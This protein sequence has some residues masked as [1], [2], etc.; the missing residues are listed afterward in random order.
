MQTLP[1]LRSDLQATPVYDADGVLY[2]DVYDPK[3]NHSV[4]LYDFEWRLAEQF[5]F[6]QTINFLQ[7][8]ISKELQFET[9]VEDL[10]TYVQNLTR[11]GWFQVIP[12]K[13]NIQPIETASPP[14]RSPLVSTPFPVSVA[15]SIQNLPPIPETPKNAESLISVDVVPVSSESSIVQEEPGVSSSCTEMQADEVPSRVGRIVVFAM[16]LLS[17]VGLGYLLYLLFSST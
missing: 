14:P 9:S 11:L 8:W 7:F 13:T 2:Y 15:A 6:S 1:L 10:N 4:R 16:L 5:K 12:S 17:M 3:K